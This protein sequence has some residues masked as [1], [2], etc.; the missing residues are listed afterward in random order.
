MRYAVTVTR[1]VTYIEVVTLEAPTKDDA[2]DLALEKVAGL[3][4]DG[5]TFKLLG[6]KDEVGDI[7][8]VNI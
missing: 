6:Y 7:L 1:R 2:Y 8:D 5:S 4:T 3:K